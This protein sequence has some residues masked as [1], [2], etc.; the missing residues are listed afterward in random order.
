MRKSALPVAAFA[1]LIAALAAAPEPA[2]ARPLAS[3]FSLAWSE[4]PSW[5]VFDVA[6]TKEKL[7]DGRK[8]EMGPL[9]KKW[10]VDVELAEL[11][12]D[13]CM[14]GYVASKYDAVCITNMDALAP[15]LT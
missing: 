15:A 6:S 11:D 9:E 13:A 14:K 1:A 8:G 10:N 3:T 5:S 4:Y 2:A 7:I 12:Y